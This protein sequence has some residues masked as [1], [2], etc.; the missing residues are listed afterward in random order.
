MFYLDR[1]TKERYDEGKFKSIIE[2]YEAEER[3]IISIVKG[4]RKIFIQE[5]DGNGKYDMVQLK[6]MLKEHKNFYLPENTNS[7][8]PLSFDI[9]NYEEI[10]GKIDSKDILR[11]Y[12]VMYV[13]PKE[14]LNKKWIY[15]GDWGKVSRKDNIHI[16]N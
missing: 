8:D 13:N 16:F 3:K 1:E 6:E 14:I 7:F 10:K 5:K 9:S 4:G 2:I 12:S 15:L 11:E